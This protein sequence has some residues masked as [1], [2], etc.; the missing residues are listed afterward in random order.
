M[1]PT[2]QGNNVMFVVDNWRVFKNMNNMNALD[3]EDVKMRLF[4]FSLE[5][6][7]IYWL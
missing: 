1:F 4:A 2:F 3:H 5:Y 7:V 6:D